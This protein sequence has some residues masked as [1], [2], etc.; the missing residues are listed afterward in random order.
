M[1]GHTKWRGAAGAVAVAALLALAGTA[2]VRSVHAA[3]ALMHIDPPSQNVA[4]DAASITVNVRISGANNVGSWEFAIGYNSAL[5]ELVD[6]TEGPFLKSTG[7]PTTCHRS[8][9]AAFLVASAKTALGTDTA[10]V[11]QYGC[12]ITAEVNKFTGPSGDGVLGTITLKPKKSGIANLVFVKRD[13]GSPG[14]TTVD[15]E[16]ADG[17]VQVGVTGGALQPT[18]TANAANLTP[19][20][21]PTREIDPFIHGADQQ[22][23]SSNTSSNPRTNSSSTQSQPTPASG[24][25]VDPSVYGPPAPTGSVLASNTAPAADSGPLSGGGDLAT[26]NGAQGEG[27]SGFPR[28]GYGPQSS[29]PD[30]W[31]R[32]SGVSLF[33]LGALL[34][35]VGI[36]RGRRRAR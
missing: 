24:V 18:P 27:G 36:E 12:Q 17:V 30:P 26:G 5:V 23:A 7:L 15:V 16:S 33:V 20:A 11:A 35:I 9:D 8:A 14:A 25:A 22:A 32:R 31:W 19:V 28:A 2:A 21:L 34:V 1:G 3:G 13:L 4:T 10:A 6:I 29:G